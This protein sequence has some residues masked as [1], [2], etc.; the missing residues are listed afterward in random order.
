M[1][2]IVAIEGGDFLIRISADEDAT[3]PILKT[4]KSCRQLANV[5]DQIDSYLTSN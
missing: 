3:Y 1:F 2:L 4:Q 5:N